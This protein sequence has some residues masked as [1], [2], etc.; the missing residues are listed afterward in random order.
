VALLGS[1]RTRL[2][3][4]RMNLETRDR[5]GDYGSAS[6]IALP[7]LADADCVLALRSRS[8]RALATGSGSIAVDLSAT[9]HID[10]PTLCE[11]ST[12]LRMI[13]RHKAKIAVV[14]ADT[15]IRWVLEVCGI[16]GVGF[17][18]TM[19]GALAEMRRDQRAAARPPWRRVRRRDGTAL[20]DSPGRL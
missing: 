14:G 17:H 1:V 8:E 18:A 7:R 16:D 4:K 2:E 13:S 6:V 3:Q 9:D 5:S 20:K 15:R 10:T 12:A 19:R 11:L